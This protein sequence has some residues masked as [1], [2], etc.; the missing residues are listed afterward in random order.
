MPKILEITL[1][2]R[3]CFFFGQEIVFGGA[4]GEDERRRS[5]LVH[6]GL[7]PQQTSL[8]GALREAI[9]RRNNALLPPQG[10]GTKS[11]ASELVGPKSFTLRET[12]QSFGAIRKLSPVAIREKDGLTWQPHPQDDVIGKKNA[13]P[14]KA[15]IR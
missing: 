8:L 1:T 5:Y 9:L 11:R 7:L 6:S 13:L 4:K 12:D 3:G 15:T 10:S 2:P 14:N